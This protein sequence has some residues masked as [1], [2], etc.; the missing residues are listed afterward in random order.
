MRLRRARAGLCYRCVLVAA[1]GFLLQA[2]ADLSAD[3]EGP[4]WL[5]VRLWAESPQLFNPTALD[6]DDLGRVWVTEAVNYRLWNNPGAKG[7]PEGDRVV[8]L[9]DTDRDGRC[10]SSRVFVQ[11]PELVAPL[12][13]LVQTQT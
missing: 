13:I 10:D 8:V 9:E 7:R 6:V 4:A 1:F 2:P 5:E 12:G 11:D 3:F